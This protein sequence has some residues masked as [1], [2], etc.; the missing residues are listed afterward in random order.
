MKASKGKQLENRFVRKDG[1]LKEEYFRDR[2]KELEE[3]FRKRYP[4]AI[5]ENHNNKHG[6]R[7]VV[8][9]KRNE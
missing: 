2:V 7:I 3:Y 8:Y 5:I 6:T 1:F 9:E 4:N